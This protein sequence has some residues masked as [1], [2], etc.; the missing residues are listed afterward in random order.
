MFL[1]D[2]SKSPEMAQKAMEFAKQQ[3]LKKAHLESIAAGEKK[4]AQAS[5]A[6]LA[7]TLGEGARAHL[8]GMMAGEQ[9]EALEAQQAAGQAPNPNQIKTA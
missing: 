3:F 7:K 9:T 6:E 4:L 8:S 2:A 1:I 5:S